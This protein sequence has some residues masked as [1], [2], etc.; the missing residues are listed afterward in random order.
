LYPT[1]STSAEETISRLSKQASVFGNLRQII[2]DRDTAFTSNLFKKY[3]V[4][5]NIEHVSIAAGVP[6]GNGQVERI[7]RIVI[8]ILT[9]FST[10]H[11]ET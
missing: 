11:P 8:P 6:R 5:E 9:K 7:N 2:S 1:K 4:D 3:R 10:P